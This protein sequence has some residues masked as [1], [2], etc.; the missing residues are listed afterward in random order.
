MLFM[1]RKVKLGDQKI[2][3]NTPIPFTY[4]KKTIQDNGRMH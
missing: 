4:V 3:D 2:E 1:I